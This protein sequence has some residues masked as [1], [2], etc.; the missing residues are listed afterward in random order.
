MTLADTLHA[1]HSDWRPSAEDDR[2]HIFAAIRTAAAEHHG[3]VHAA[4]VRRHLTRDVNPARIGAAFG[5]LVSQGVL[6]FAGRYER[7]GGVRSRNGN[8]PSPVYLLMGD[9]P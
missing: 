1:V 2:A 8:K 7:N 3:E 5:A 4:T 9:L 6:V